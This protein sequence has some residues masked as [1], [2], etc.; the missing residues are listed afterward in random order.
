MTAPIG[1]IAVNLAPYWL[2]AIPES[3][4]IK[5]GEAFEY[6]LPGYED[7]EGDE[8]TLTVNLGPSKIFLTFTEELGAF[9]IPVDLTKESDAGT[10]TIKL[11]LED[12]SGMKTATTFVLNIEGPVQEETSEEESSNSDVGDVYASKIFMS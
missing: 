6:T 8:V 3:F 9:S 1:G 2:G 7:H 12:S 5:F 4:T 11:S 10:Y